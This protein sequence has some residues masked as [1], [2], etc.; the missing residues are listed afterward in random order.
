L[1]GAEVCPRTPLSERG[2]GVKACCTVSLDDVN[3]GCAVAFDRWTSML[4]LAFW[5]VVG[6]DACPDCPCCK[7]VPP[8]LPLLIML[9]LIL[10]SDVEFRQEEPH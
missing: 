2:K 9:P 1:S 3:D 8:Q 7:T 4:G 10:E 5:T 6:V